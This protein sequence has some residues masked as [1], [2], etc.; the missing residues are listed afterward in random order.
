[1][2]AGGGAG[3]GFGAGAGDVTVAGL[4]GASASQAASITSALSAAQRRIIAAARN[5]MRGS[6]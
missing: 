3:A 4:P 6:I 5:T 2:G 1:M